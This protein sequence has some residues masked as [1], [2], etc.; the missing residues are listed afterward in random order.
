MIVFRDVGTSGKFLERR[1]QV[2]TQPCFGSFASSAAH[3]PSRQAHQTD[4]QTRYAHHRHTDEGSR[5]RWHAEGDRHSSCNGQHHKLRHWAHPQQVCRFETADTTHALLWLVLTHLLWLVTLVP[6][7]AMAVS[8]LSSSPAQLSAPLPRSPRSPHSQR[9]SALSSQPAP[10]TAFRSAPSL[11]GASLRLTSTPLGL[12]FHFGSGTSHVSAAFN[13]PAR[14]PQ[15]RS[16]F[17]RAHALSS[18]VHNR[19]TLQTQTTLEFSS[20]R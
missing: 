12:A 7:T 13:S 6:L 14:R 16:S 18:T 2:E 10:L 8:P 4:R 15:H 19:Q 17:G 5:D 1:E 3:S 20:R 9:L 11:V